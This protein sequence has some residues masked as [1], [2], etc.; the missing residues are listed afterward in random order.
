MSQFSVNVTAENFQQTVIENSEKVPVLI[1][2]W[3][4]W[5]GPCKQVMPMLEALVEEYT[6]RFILAKVN[7]EEQQELA[8]HFAIQSIP[9]FKLAVNGK[10]VEEM[11][12]AQPLGEFRKLLD[13]YV[14]I[15]ESETLRL[16]AKSL[17]EQGEL[18]EAEKLLSQ[19]SQINPNN[20]KIHLD[21]AQVYVLQN[22][23][24][25]AIKLLE[26]LPENVQNS[27]E[28]KAIF[29]QAQLALQMANGP[30]LEEIEKQLAENPNDLVALKTLSQIQL[31]TSEYEAAMQTL[32]KIF[33]IDRN[34]EEDFARKTLFELFEQLKQSHSE[35]VTNYRRKLQ[36]LLF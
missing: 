31:A 19:A 33:S 11:Q 24:D 12:G 29:K 25:N 21:I 6:G 22:E 3:A 36:S 27:N 2:F 9:S 16:Q 18:A 23:A 14:A 13:K 34:F 15:D 1:D 17:S 4:P 5:C 32:L 35:L 26:Q 8:S 20:F 7:T 30:S 28:G 10:I